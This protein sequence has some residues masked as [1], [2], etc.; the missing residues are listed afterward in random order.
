MQKENESKTQG[1]MDIKRTSV[2]TI[3]SF[4]LLNNIY[5]QT[6]PAIIPFDM[7]STGDPV[8]EDIRFLSLASG[9]PFLSFSPPLSPEEIWLFI[10]SINETTLSPPAMEAY[11][12]IQ[13]RLNPQ[14]NLSISKGLFTAFLN[15]NSTVEARVKFNSAIEQFPSNQA[16][17]PFISLP[18]RFFFS[19]TLQLY[20]EP[21]LTMRPNKYMLDTFDLNIPTDYF[22]YDETMPLK[23]FLAAG[24]D[25]WSFQIG[26]DRLFWGTG[27]TGS[28]T[29][30]DN[31]QY[32]D[33]A[34]LSLFSSVFKYSMIV[35]QLPMTLSRELFHP[36]NE[37]ISAW[38]DDPA[39]RIRTIHRYYYLQRLD[40]TLFNRLSIGVMEGIMVG[41]SPL[42][43]RYLNPF[44]IFHS[45][46]SWEDYD[47][48]QPP[49][50]YDDLKPGDMIGSI[51]SLEVNWNII[52]NLSF[53]GQFVMNEFAERGER[54]RNP[55]QPPNGLGYLAGLQFSHSFFSTWTSIFFLEFIYTDPYLNIL[56]S[57]FGSFIQQNRY[58]Q[59]YYL[60][61]PRDTIALTLG[62][63][64]FR[65]NNLNLSG[66]FSWIANG[67]HNKH[68]LIW[69]WERTPDAARQTT[70]TG[71]A[72]NNLVLSLN[73]GWKPLS[74]LSLNTSLVGIVS[75]NNLHISGNNQ[76]GGQT[77]FFAGF[78]Y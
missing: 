61:Y 72:E 48:W 16:I 45:L 47:T 60:G 71:I 55:N 9:Q 14:A 54:Q 44:R 10:E 46:F 78:H 5:S 73:A 8:L 21:S 32:F 59:Y 53:Y 7:I 4:L 31:S 28:L 13:E 29:F 20:A 37:I 66:K 6:S 30:S 33:F 56:S 24:G 50:V 52:R 34:R 58:G 23:F 11:N 51:F 1:I 36:D 43:L 22:E 17:N 25:W 41:N 76:V 3:F 70:S 62:A 42:E 57:P 40:F 75:H 38:W 15:A 18:I 26:R 64:F 69:N 35:N 12:R 65:Q 63:N 2:I 68:G 74:W 49:P 39:N 67:E 27:H 19:D 77:S